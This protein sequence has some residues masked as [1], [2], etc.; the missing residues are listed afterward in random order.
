[1]SVATS[2]RDAAVLYRGR[3]FA[4]CK[5]DPTEK[6]PTY[7]GWS[8]R[9]LDPDD[10]ERADQVGILGG[11][12]SDAN[13]PEHALVTVD[14]DDHDAV[15]GADGYLPPTAMAEGRPGKPRSHRY[16]LVP[17][18][19]IPEWAESKADQASAAARRN[20]GHPGPF[21]KQFSHR[22]TAK[23]VIDFIG[24]GGQVVCPPAMWTSADGARTERREW[25]GGAPG[26]PAVVPFLSLWQA[27]CEL[28]S[29]CG[30]E[31]PDVVPRT[32]RPAVPRAQ[33]A[34]ANVID[35]ALK[36]LAKCEGAVSGQAGHKATFFAA[37][38]LVWG[39]D[40]DTDTALDLLAQHYNSR[41]S[42]PWSECE[43]QH[44]VQDADR[45]PFEANRGATSAMRYSGP[46]TA[47]RTRW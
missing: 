28:A 43:L 27:V 15:T 11:P 10:F 35:R 29:A 36:Y 22:E 23:C 31:I 6:K 41:C 20:K 45:V 4:L 30:A 5:P 34:E 37:R 12:L 47:R 9:S 16:Y 33:R 40:L 46:V 3:G 44:K 19:S 39:F 38:A 14:L 32:P 18:D 25:D 26:E 8:S 7:K 21:K 24:T 13:R 17:F 42:P 2:T 1:M